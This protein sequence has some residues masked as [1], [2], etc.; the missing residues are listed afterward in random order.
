MFT[1]FEG[2][3]DEINGFS[4]L[5]VVMSGRL[6]SGKRYKWKKSAVRTNDQQY[7]GVL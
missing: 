1:K 6:A 2:K 7:D 3:K 4:V 5:T